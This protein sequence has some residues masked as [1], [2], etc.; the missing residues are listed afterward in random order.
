MWHKAGALWKFNELILTDHS[1]RIS[2]NFNNKSQRPIS[3]FSPVLNS[4]WK[5][6]YSNKTKNNLSSNFESVFLTQN[7]G[8][9]FEQDSVRD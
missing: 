1:A 9:I 8:S 7:L 3:L 5:Q 4:H 6:N 2:L